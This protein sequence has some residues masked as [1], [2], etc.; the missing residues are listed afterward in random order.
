[1]DHFKFFVLGS[2]TAATETVGKLRRSIAYAEI[3]IN[4]RNNPTK[5]LSYLSHKYSL[6]LWLNENSD[7]NEK[8]S[9]NYNHLLIHH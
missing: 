8:E 2:G 5:A 1:M 7:D 4:L 3:R 6:R 9:K